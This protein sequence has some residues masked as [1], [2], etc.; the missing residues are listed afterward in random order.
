MCTTW[1]RSRVHHQTDRLALSWGRSGDGLSAREME[2]KSATQT[3]SASCVVYPGPRPGV[4]SQ[5]E[6]NRPA[7]RKAFQCLGPCN[8]LTSPAQE[9]GTR[10]LQQRRLTV[11]CSA[12]ATRSVCGWDTLQV[13][14]MT[15]GGIFNLSL[16]FPV[17]SQA[18]PLLS[19]SLFLT[20]ALSLSCFPALPFYFLSAGTG[21]S[22]GPPLLAFSVLGHFLCL[23]FSH[24][25]PPHQLFWHLTPPEGAGL[26]QWLGGA[27]PET[28]TTHSR[29]VRGSPC[30]S[31]CSGNPSFHPHS[32]ILS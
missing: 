3:R 21:T 12:M 17:L 15:E 26:H 7:S 28:S 23:S 27:P 20:C 13:S 24:P 18:P 31:S 8:G 22:L 6:Q 19:C 5:R 14:G 11:K 16:A 9:E 25:P 2:G 10:S 4:S 30:P 1:V 29:H 32:M